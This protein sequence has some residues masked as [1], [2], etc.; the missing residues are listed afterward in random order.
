MKRLMLLAAAIMLAA[1]GMWGLGSLSGMGNPGSAYPVPDLDSLSAGQAH[2]GNGQYVEYIVGE[3][4]LILSAP[5]GGTHMPSEIRNRT[6]GYPIGDSGT[7]ELTRLIAHALFERTGR[8]PH[9]VIS[10]LARKKL[11][12]NRTIGEAA[13]GDSLAEQAWLD[14]HG[15]IDA[16]KDAVTNTW[17]S[18]LYLDIHGH[19]HRTPW[20]ELGYVINNDALNG[21]DDTLNRMRRHA[22]RSLAE[23]SPQSVS[24]L[25]RGPQSLGALLVE[26]GYRSV[27]SPDDPSPGR[28]DY[29]SGGY[30]T[31][32]HGSYFGGP[33]DGIQVEHPKRGVRDTDANRRTYA[34]HFADVLIAYMETHYGFVLQNEQTP[35]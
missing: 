17:G 11:D 20:V 12:P 23:A 16:A 18:G 3:L 19:G 35:D 22:L 2:W 32:R 28:A 9:V 24:E 13:D 5:H 6:R 27:P 7:Q 31:Y 29:F 30:S 4:P 25:V 34:K 10:R 33:I 15:F 21:P 14:Y 26:K 1:T 8:M